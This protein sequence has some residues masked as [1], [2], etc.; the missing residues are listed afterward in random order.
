MF[1]NL[2]TIIFLLPLPLYVPNLHQDMS[3]SI[4]A[5]QA[6]L[7]KQTEELNKKRNEDLEKISGMI[8]VSVKAHIG[9]L[10]KRQLDFETMATGQIKDLVSEVANI[11]QMFQQPISNPSAHPSL[12][13]ALPPAGPPPPGTIPPSGQP[14]A[15]QPPP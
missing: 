6:L 4:E 5:I 9:P 12:A 15:S 7:D 10:E 14:S 2:I 3:A 11:K 1:S 8:D 13:R